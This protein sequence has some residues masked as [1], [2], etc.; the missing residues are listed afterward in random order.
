MFDFLALRHVRYLL[1]NQGWNV[2]PLCWKATSEPL[3]ARE[4][5]KV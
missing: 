3:I 4:V 1:P 5:P 2:H